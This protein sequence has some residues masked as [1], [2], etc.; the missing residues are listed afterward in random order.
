MFSGAL[1]QNSHFQAIAAQLDKTRKHAKGDVVMVRY[2][3]DAVLG[4]QKHRDARECLSA[5]KQRL[6]KFGLKVHP[7]KNRLVRGSLW[8]FRPEPLQGRAGKTRN[9]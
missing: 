9:V 4:F 6:G 5:L 1:P 2:A 8:A 7:E 3:D